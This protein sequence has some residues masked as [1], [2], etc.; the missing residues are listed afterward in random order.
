MSICPALGKKASR[1]SLLLVHN[2]FALLHFRSP[3]PRPL[4]LYPD[5]DL[6]LSLS[7]FCSDLPAPKPISLF[8]RARDFQ[9]SPPLPSC[10]SSSLLHPPLVLSSK[11]KHSIPS[12]LSQPTSPSQCPST[13]SRQCPP[14]GVPHLLSYPVF[15]FCSPMHCPSPA[16]LQPNSS[17]KAAKRTPPS[18]DRAHPCLVPISLQPV[19]Q[20]SLPSPPST[21]ASFEN[22]M[23]RPLRVTNEKPQERRKSTRTREAGDFA[24]VCWPTDTLEHVPCFLESVL[25][26]AFVSFLSFLLCAL[27]ALLLLPG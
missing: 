27:F 13:P 24:A 11:S 12:L 18:T 19:L 4:P 1:R 15:F 23:H 6:P 17:I 5:I 21:H 3:V 8:S 7:L 9:R 20:N 22:P 26:L 10:R 14:T 2:R 25:L 16:K